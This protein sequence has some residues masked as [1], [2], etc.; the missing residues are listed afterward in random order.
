MSLCG[1]VAEGGIFLICITVPKGL[2]CA[3]YDVRE[4]LHARLLV[5][6]VHNSFRLDDI[7]DGRF[8]R[9]LLFYYTTDGTTETPEH[10]G[11]QLIL[12]S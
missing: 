10:V 5:V 8:L 1:K 7:F 3:F 4:T 9:F 12:Q 6:V 11:I 2:S